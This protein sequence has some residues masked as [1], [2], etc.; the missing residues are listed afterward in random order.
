[1]WELGTLVFLRYTYLTIGTFCSENGLSACSILKTSSLSLHI[2]R[3]VPGF[4]HFFLVRRDQLLS[5]RSDS[6]TNHRY[7]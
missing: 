5:L 6:M 2:H 3:T 7:V 1:M 4:P